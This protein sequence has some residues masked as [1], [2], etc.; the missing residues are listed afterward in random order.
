MRAVQLRHY[1]QAG[2]LL[3]KGISKTLY[4]RDRGTER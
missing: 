2:I 1:R 4:C 3:H